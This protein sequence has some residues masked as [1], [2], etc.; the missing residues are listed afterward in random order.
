MLLLLQ[1]FFA[2]K[3][4]VDAPVAAH[5][6]LQ[7]PAFLLKVKTTR[8]RQTSTQEVPLIAFLAPGLTFVAA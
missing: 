6:S 1:E 3:C 8:K 5:T 2:K 7:F 4:R